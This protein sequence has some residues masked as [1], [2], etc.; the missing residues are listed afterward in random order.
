M[1]LCQHHFHLLR[2]GQPQMSGVFQQAQTF[3]GNI[4]ENDRSPQYASGANDL[5]VKNVGDPHED[6][7]QHL[8][9]DAFKTHF[10][11]QLFITDRT[12]HSCD[13]VRHHKGQQRIQQAVTTAKI[14][15]KPAPDSCKIELNRVPELFHN[16]ILLKKCCIEKGSHREGE[17]PVFLIN[18]II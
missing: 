16:G 7:N 3:I 12:H 15:A 8:P 5:Y 18:P 10:A 17:L 13:I 1:E 2:N 9:A 4:K 14:L 11:G 6:K